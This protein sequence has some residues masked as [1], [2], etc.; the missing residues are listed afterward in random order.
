VPHD[1]HHPH[2][3]DHPHDAT[4]GEQAHGHTHG[5]RDWA[6]FGPRL[7]LEGEVAMPLLH[8]AFDAITR[9]AGSVDGIRSVLDLGSGPGVAS[10]ALAQRFPLAAVTAVDASAPLLEFARARAARFGVGERVDTRVADFERSLG[11]IA[12]VGGTD[13]VWASM[14]LHHVVDLPRMLADVH[15]LLRPGGVVAVVELARPHGTLPAGFDVGPPGFVDRFNDAVTMAL[16]EHLPAGAMSLD[17]P[18]L[19][20]EAGFALLDHRELAMHLQAPLDDAA[21]R[22]ALQELQTSAQR[23]PQHLDG[24]DREVLATLVDL[25]DPACLVHRDDLTYAITRTFL[26]GRRL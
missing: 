17:W 9:V 4:H 20:T 23:V 6:T 14:V 10:V 25:T 21:R 22:L 11:D 12:A 18:A 13:M 15:R 8:Q 3:H 5:E 2:G 16:E 7:D 26:L 24:A 1:H 19:L